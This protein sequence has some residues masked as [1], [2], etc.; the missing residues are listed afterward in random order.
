MKG[1]TTIFLMIIKRVRENP[2]R[3]SQALGEGSNT[4]TSKWMYLS[5]RVPPTNEHSERLVF[6]GC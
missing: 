3:G 5:S 2:W 6:T 1:L 4:E